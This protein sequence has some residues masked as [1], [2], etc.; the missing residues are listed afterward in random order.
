[1][2]AHDP[3]PAA[4][5]GLR[6]RPPAETARD[7]LAWFRATDG[8]ALTGISRQRETQLLGSGPT[9]GTA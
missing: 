7:T 9:A 3:G 8:A 2:L 6:T 4:S 5:A 1:M